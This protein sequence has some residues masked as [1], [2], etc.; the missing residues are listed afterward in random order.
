MAGLIQEGEWVVVIFN[1]KKMRLVQVGAKHEIKVKRWR[2]STEGMVGLPYGVELDAIPDDDADVEGRKRN[3]KLHE[4]MEVAAAAAAEQGKVLPRGHAKVSYAKLSVVDS[5]VEQAEDDT[6]LF[7]QHQMELEIE[8]KGMNSLL[9]SRRGNTSSQVDASTTDKPSG[10]ILEQNT[11]ASKPG[12]PSSGTAG[13]SVGDDPEVATDHKSTM[14]I[15]LDNRNLTDLGGA[16]GGVQL[17]T[18]VEIAELRKTGGHTS[19][20]NALVE[21][22][23]TFNKKTE[24]S[25]DKYVAKKKKKYSARI[26]IMQATA[27]SIADVTWQ[28]TM[29]AGTKLQGLRA[30]DSFGHILSYGHVFAGANVM[31]VETLSGILV[32]A[33]AERLGGYGTLHAPFF[34]QQPNYTVVDYFNLKPN[35]RD[36]VKAYSILPMLHDDN[37][38]NDNSAELLTSPPSVADVELNSMD[39]LIIVTMYDPTSMLMPLIKYLAPSRPFVIFCEYQEPLARCRVAIDKADIVC[40]LRMH[41]TLTREYQVLPYRTHPAM[42]G[43]AAGGYML[44]GFKTMESDVPEG[45]KSSKRARSSSP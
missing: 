33:V 32:G 14:A 22:S 28:K 27:A 3:A 40:D 41:E 13:S 20:V 45:F 5:R 36:V 31:V 4:H 12:E 37:E 44:Y 39:S 23:E 30:V 42:R 11:N 18:H 43:S 26:R 9:E 19:I 38:S 34:G 25:K 24:Y 35:E 17:L 8:L 1:E 10:E 21:N 2:C 7:E 29:P 15:V 6:R 16:K